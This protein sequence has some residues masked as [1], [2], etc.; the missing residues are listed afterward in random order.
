MSLEVFVARIAEREGVPPEVARGH[1]RAVLSTVR[2]AVLPKEFHDIAAELPRV[3]IAE[4][5]YP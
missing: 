2:D 1:A 5:C 3:Y 4:L